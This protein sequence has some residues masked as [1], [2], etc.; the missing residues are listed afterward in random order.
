MSFKSGTSAGIAAL[1][2]PV[3]MT[4]VPSG[5]PLELL[6]VLMDEVEGESWLRFR[7]LAPAIAR[8]TG[9]L[10]FEAVAEDFEHLCRTLALPYLEEFDLSPEV[11]TVTL[12]DRDVPFGASD[13]DA[14]QYLEVFR[15]KA[16]ACVWEG[17]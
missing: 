11:V 2:R 4:D 13:P 9:G 15:I 7:F 3:D 5:Q 1:A 14:T 12:L 17:F 8:V 10:S 16:G 6:E